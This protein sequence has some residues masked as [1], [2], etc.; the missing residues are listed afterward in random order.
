MK[1]HINLKRAIFAVLI[2]LTITLFLSYNLL[3]TYSNKSVHEIQ[4]DEDI[5]EIKN[6]NKSDTLLDITGTPNELF[7]LYDDDYVYFSLKE[8]GNKII[9]KDSKDFD[10]SN[11]KFKGS[12]DE[13]KFI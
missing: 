5:V 6:L 13:L 10:L 9:I 2:A 11:T 1:I 7:K 8:F 3:F 4:T 12:F